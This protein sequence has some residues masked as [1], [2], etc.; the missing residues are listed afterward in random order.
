MLLDRRSSLSAYSASPP[1]IYLAKVRDAG[2]PSLALYLRHNRNMANLTIG[3]GASDFLSER[4]LSWKAG[5]EDWSISRWRESEWAQD[6]AASR[7]FQGLLWR[8]I[9][10]AKIGGE[11][12]EA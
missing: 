9:F 3:D 10:C 7:S 11:S 6:S 8:G 12:L 4:P 5:G 2:K 1:E